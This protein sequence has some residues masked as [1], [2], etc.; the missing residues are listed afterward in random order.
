MM[1]VYLLCLST[2]IE[3]PPLTPVGHEAHHLAP[4]GDAVR[5]G[6]AEE[7][8][9]DEAVQPLLLAATFS[10]T[11]SAGVLQLDA[12]GKLADLAPID[13]RSEQYVSRRESLVKVR[14]LRHAMRSSLICAALAQCCMTWK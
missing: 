6:F 12:L 4:A 10:R 8:F 11:S 9:G 2:M 14:M 1:A 5:L 13:S 7:L 3:A